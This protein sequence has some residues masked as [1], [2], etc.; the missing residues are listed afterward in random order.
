MTVQLVQNE[1][2]ATS[3]VQ[4]FWGGNAEAGVKGEALLNVLIN[5]NPSPFLYVEK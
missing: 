3:N 2:E 1:T 5:P 4:S